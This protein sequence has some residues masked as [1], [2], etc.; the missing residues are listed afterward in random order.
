MA[1]ANS[2]RSRMADWKRSRSPVRWTTNWRNSAPVRSGQ[3]IANHQSGAAWA[4]I[5]F[6]TTPQSARSGSKAT[7]RSSS[8]S[9]SKGGQTA[10]LRVVSA[11]CRLD[12][13][14]FALCLDRQRATQPQAWPGSKPQILT[15]GGQ[16]DPER[17][18]I[19]VIALHDGGRPPDQALDE[20]SAPGQP[21]TVREKTAFWL[22][23]YARHSRDHRPQADAGKRSQ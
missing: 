20:L 23:H 4:L 5:A 22:G 15:Q 3:V 8:S 13:G 17:A 12:A 19:S 1:Q 21:E 6:P 11:D 7:R 14:G 9:R 10:Q 18:A 16:A 2:L